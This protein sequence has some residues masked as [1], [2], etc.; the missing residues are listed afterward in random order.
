MGRSHAHFW[1]DSAAANIHVF[2]SLD[3]LFP[4]YPSQSMKFRSLMCTAL[5]GGQLHAWFHL[6]SHMAST[7][8][9]LSRWYM[10]PSI[11]RSAQASAVT[12][13]LLALAKVPFN[14]EPEHELERA[15]TAKA[16]AR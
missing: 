7:H 6:T 4:I 8:A 14:L 2:V 15:K 3:P 1:L 12:N 13:N 9:A 10:R 5:N 16:S 11:M